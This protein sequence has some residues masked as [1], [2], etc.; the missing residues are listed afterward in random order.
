VTAKKDRA[1][2][3]FPMTDS[4]NAE[5]IAQMYGDRLRFN[6]R[7]GRWLI[8][9]NGRWSEDCKG[10][11]FPMAKD[12]ARARLADSANIPDNS[13]RSDAARWALNSESEYRLRVALDLA[14]KEAPLSDAGDSWDLDPFL[15]GVSN[16]VVD[17]RTGTLRRACP[18]DRMLLYTTVHYDPSA[19]CARF[20]Q[21]LGEVFREDEETI[22]F[23]QRAIGYCLTGDVTEQ[24]LFLCY[25]EGANGKST[26]LEIVTYILGA[27]AHSLPFSSF[28]KR[29][30]SGIPNDLAGLVS[31]RFVTAAETSED[32]TL[33]EGRIKSLTGGDTC[34]ARFLYS[35]WFSFEPTAKH[36]LAFNHLPHVTDDSHGLWRRVRLIPF[37]AKFDGERRDNNLKETL[38][39]EASGILAWAVR[40]CLLWKAEGLGLPTAVKEATTLYQS[41]CDP[42][43]AFLDETYESSPH[44]FVES[45][46]LH[47]DY[48][49]WTED[50]GKK[51]LNARD[52]ASRLRAHGFTQAKLGHARTRGW[53]GLKR[54]EDGVGNTYADGRTDANTTLH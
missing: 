20:E 38:R 49:K 14:K 42:L 33:N 30:H 43:A 27:Y 8:W 3:S 28:E 34:S 9:K 41:E 17:L 51:P 11:V 21:F 54:K 1:P 44:G 48:K 23:I 5:L 39:A 45:A 26:L 2:H 40:G 29:A 37:L 53:S 52:L 16:G 31:K 19:Q 15:L 25:G 32:V 13:R 7:R 24:V 35:E 18:E 4:G 36:W 6:H 46:T 22:R 47:R 50:N 10:E 12:V